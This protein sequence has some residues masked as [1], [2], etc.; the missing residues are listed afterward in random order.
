MKIR[1]PSKSNKGFTL[2]EMFV[3][4]FAIFVI[5]VVLFVGVYSS[6]LAGNFWFTEEG[7]LKEIRLSEA[8]AK[9]V[10]TSKRGVWKDSE[11]TVELEDGRRQVFTL[12][13]NILFNYEVK[14]K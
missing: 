9:T 5:V 6:L 4:M 1:T 2:G 14:P 11:I 13:T 8:K 10:L 7:V 12:D 3:V